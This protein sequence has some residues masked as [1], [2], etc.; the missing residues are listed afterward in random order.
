MAAAEIYI[1]RQRDLVDK[2]FELR[3][4]YLYIIGRWKIRHIPG[5]FQGY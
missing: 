4:D 5:A 1:N 2:D 3:F